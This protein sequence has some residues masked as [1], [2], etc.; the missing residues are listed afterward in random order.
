MVA[1]Y[2]P[3][4]VFGVIVFLL[5]GSW[6]LR[7]Y[8]QSLADYYVIGRRANWVIY[9]CTLCATWV[10]MWTL[11]GGPGLVW[12]GWGPFQI[13]S[14][15][16]GSAIGIIFCT[17]ILAPALRRGRYLTLP[18][19]FAERFASRRVRSAA[20]AA[21]IV[22][23]YF[24]IV[25]QVVGGGIMFEQ[26]LGLTYLQGMLVFLG[27]V[28]VCLLFSGMWSIVL[29]DVFGFIVFM[30]AGLVF[31]IAIVKM[32][33]GLEA[34]IKGA[35]A[36][37]GAQ[38]WTMLG[39]S[40][41]TPLQHLGNV[42]SWVIILGAS[43]HLIVRSYIVK[44][45][46]DI[47]KGGIATLIAGSALTFFLFLGFVALTNLVDPKSMH[48]DYVAVHASLK[49]LP[50]V[51]GIL[52]IA[53]AFTAGTTTA[54]A[55]Y[56]TCAQ[57]LARDLYQKLLRPKATDIEVIRVT[58]VALILIGVATAIVAAMRPWL[59]V[60]AGTITGMILSFGYFPTLT[61]GLFWGRLTARA[62]EWTLWISVPLSVF[63]VYTWTKFKWFQP[64]PTIWGLILGFGLAVLLSFLTKQSEEEKAAWERLRPI[65]WPEKA[66]LLR[67][68]RDRLFI[69]IAAVLAILIGLI[70]MGLY[71]GWFW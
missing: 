52:Y 22:G 32:V 39:K 19:F 37:H 66:T 62:V 58:Y 14:W 40:G 41:L 26:M 34:A 51:L 61:L 13:Q 57:G 71:L 4:G 6:I 1:W 67:E 17:F 43:P 55:Q 35:G 46:K 47:Y 48:P 2:Y 38:Y 18:D 50:P 16:I 56:L 54:N 64:H 42:L 69:W 23:V 25:L 10:S 49:I 31:P 27:V 5:V 21:L 33:G 63:A 59:L 28:L 20:V 53:G 12:K 60:I 8:V 30:V 65:L 24:Y 9:A 7:R 44:D 36:I 45:T 3:A 68:V 70:V 29:T 11:M 15:Y